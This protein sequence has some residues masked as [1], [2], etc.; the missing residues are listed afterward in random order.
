MGSRLVDIAPARIQPNP[1]QPRKRFNEESL[2]ELAQSI[3][4]QGVIQPVVVRRVDGVYQLIAGERRVRAAKLAGVKTVPARVIDDPVEGDLEKAVVENIQ[5]EDLNAIYEAV[6]F[7]EMIER[8]KLTQE[9]VAE[10]VGKS[11]TA[12]ANTLRLLKL[13]EAIQK[14]LLAGLLTEGHARA[15]L[16]APDA[17]R[18]MDFRNQILREG[19]SVRQ[20]ERLV[21]PAGADGKPSIQKAAGK[22]GGPVDP[23]LLDVQQ[24]MRERLGTRVTIQAQSAKKGRISIPYNTLNDFERIMEALGI[25]I[26]D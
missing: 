21:R 25:S 1:D 11:R 4:S 20:A 12:V 7:Q 19:L 16:M 6:A 17:K 13:P 23:I 10:R 15:L 2:R 22:K 3:R 9:Q 14:D 5:R 24:K 18:Q 8:G 26:E